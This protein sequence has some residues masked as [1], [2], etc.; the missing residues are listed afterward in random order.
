[1]VILCLSIGQ[2][3]GIQAQSEAKYT[4]AMESNV[5]PGRLQERSLDRP[6]L[7]FTMS[8]RRHPPN[9]QHLETG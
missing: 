9:V 2:K 4:S 7:L 5:G 8:A 1:M 6:P 3:K